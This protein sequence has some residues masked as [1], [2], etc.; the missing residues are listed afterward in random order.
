L[1]KQGIAHTLIDKEDFPR[2]KVCGDGLTLEVLHTLGLIAPDLLSSFLHHK[3]FLPIWEVKF[4]SPSGK[5]LSLRFDEYRLPFA[6]VYTGKRMDF[7]QFL[8]SHT[9]SPFAKVLKNTRVS[10]IQPQKDA[11]EISMMNQDKSVDSISA[12]LIVGADGDRSI[13]YKSLNGNPGYHGKYY[14]VGIRAY[15]RGITSISTNTTLEFYFLPETLP[16]YFWIFPLPGNHFNTG[17]YIPSERVRNQGLNMREM[18]SKLIQDHP[19]ISRRFYDATLEGSVQGWKLPLSTHHRKLSGERYML[20]GDA[21]A[22]IEPFTGKGI[23][24]GMLSAKVAA[25]QIHTAVS[26][27]RFDADSLYPYHQNMYRRYHSEW[28]WSRRLQRAFTYPFM[29]DM[30]ANILTSPMLTRYIDRKLHSWMREWM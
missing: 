2:D 15:F 4:F 8:I 25:E 6:P 18:L 26:Q 14:A 13:V 12:S 20:L 17:L 22:L 5:E 27:G 21:G 23:G 29:A 24:I 28:L 11:I 1:S 19:V 3:A 30:L 10:H 7:D 16:G 9:P